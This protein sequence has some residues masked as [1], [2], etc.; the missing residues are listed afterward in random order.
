MQRMIKYNFLLLISTVSI[1]GM[2]QKQISH[3]KLPIQIQYKNLN[4][5]P[6][7]TK[8]VDELDENSE[9]LICFENYKNRIDLQCDLERPDIKHSYCKQCLDNWLKKQNSCPK[10]IR[11]I[12]YPM[13]GHTGCFIKIIVF[14]QKL[15]LCGA[16]E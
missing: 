2:D 16:S 15:C 7:I 10:C 1:F 13:S 9:C 12:N 5:K 8:K 6:K 3:R 11:D 14:F 4:P